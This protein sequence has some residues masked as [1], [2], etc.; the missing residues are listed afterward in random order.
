MKIKKALAM[1]CTAALIGSLAGCGGSAEETKAPEKETEKATEAAKEETTGGS[2]EQETG[3]G[4]EAA[5][6]DTIYL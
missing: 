2:G 3:G 5:S 4:S 1:L 6:G